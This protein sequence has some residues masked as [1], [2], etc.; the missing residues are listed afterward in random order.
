M[1]ELSVWSVSSVYIIRIDL[2][3]RDTEPLSLRPHPP[4]IQ[5]LRIRTIVYLNKCISP[6]SPQ[7][8][9]LPTIRPPL[10]AGPGG[11]L[12]RISHPVP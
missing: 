11:S 2:V 5:S 12:T 6:D 9:S 10:L 7:T 8:N 1:H 3:T 4:N